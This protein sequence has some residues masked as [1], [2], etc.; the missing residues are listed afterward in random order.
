MLIVVEVIKYI[1]YDKFKELDF[2]VWICIF[3]VYGVIKN[4]IY[5]NV[6]EINE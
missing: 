5:V 1:E 3:F 6:Y 2:F 4:K